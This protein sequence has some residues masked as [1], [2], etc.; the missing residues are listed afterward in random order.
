M[1]RLNRYVEEQAP[2]KLAK[3]EVQAA[4]LDAV[5]HALAAG[6]RLVAIALSPVIPS[7][8]AE[9]LRRLG[10]AQTMAT[11]CSSGPSGMG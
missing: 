5:L 11:C 6:L 9:I 10:R 3:D 8:S 1:R 7:T 4:R 2:W